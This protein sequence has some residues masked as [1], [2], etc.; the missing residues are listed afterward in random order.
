MFPKIPLGSDV[1]P[2]T[3]PIGDFNNAVIGTIHARPLEF[4]FGI[5]VLVLLVITVIMLVAMIRHAR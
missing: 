4:V 1:L 5:P 2:P 3:A